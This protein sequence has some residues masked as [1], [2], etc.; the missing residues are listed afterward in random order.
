MCPIFV[1]SVDNFG[2]MVYIKNQDPVLISGQITIFKCQIWKS[3]LKLTLTAGTASLSLDVFHFVFLADIW[4]W[5]DKEGTKA[6]ES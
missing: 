5:V 3:N 4:K 2:K 1:V 6:L